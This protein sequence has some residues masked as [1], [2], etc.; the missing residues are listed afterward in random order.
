MKEKI[1]NKQWA[2]IFAV[3]WFVF[4]MMLSAFTDL[5]EDEAYYWLFAKFLD[6]GYFDH[7][8]MIALMIKAGGWLLPAE[9]GIR[10]FTVLFSSLSL[11][12]LF[13]IT[14]FRK[15]GL[16]FLL[17]LSVPAFHAFGFISAPDV[18]LMF[19][20]AL[21]LWLFKCYLEKD[22]LKNT[23]LLGL[24]ASL[25]MYSK[26]HGILLIVF[27][28]LPNLKLL[29]RKSFWLTTFIALLLF[30]PHIWWQVQNDYPSL[31]YHLVDRVNRNYEFRFTYEYLLGQMAFC[32]PLLFLLFFRFSGQVV[33]PF[34]KTMKWTAILVL[35]FFLVFSFRTF[36]EANW[37]AIAYLPMLLFV[38]GVLEK[39]DLARGWKTLAYFSV[40]VLVVFR[41]AL[42][43]PNDVL[44][45]G[46]VKQFYRDKEFF[47]KV[48]QVAGDLPVVFLNTYQKPSK[49]SFY[50]GV[51]SFSINS[52]WYRRNQFDKWPIQKDLQGKTVMIVGTD[53]FATAQK[54]EGEG[55]Y[56]LKEEDFK[57]YGYV[58]LMLS[59]RDFEQASG[60]VLKGALTVKNQWGDSLRYDTIPMEI[61]VVVKGKDKEF[62]FTVAKI[63][64][65]DLVSGSRIPFEIPAIPEKG[66]YK[67]IFGLNDDVGITL[68]NSSVY[69]LTVK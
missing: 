39:T 18:P 14:E 2:L 38:H 69:S 54:L 45:F 21:Y 29:A 4:N 42:M 37:G 33:S 65:N 28:L 27:T 20:G 64:E 12:V 8:P 50:Y 44:K 35:F 17:F 56:Y 22:S 49:Y 41:I 46:F 68:W 16:M 34:N 53:P 63:M 15:V 48:R 10:L 66:E 52:F 61:G 31:Q 36:I 3:T 51:P 55:V 40:S 59:K 24:V 60:Q 1:S 43:F 9:A 62:R 11:C 47:P 30:V 6:W 57:S 25:M 26:Y 58:Q 13:C 19:F 32:G 67:L 5:A 7:P 23:L